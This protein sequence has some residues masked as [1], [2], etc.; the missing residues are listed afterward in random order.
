MY[1][2]VGEYRRFGSLIG[3]DGKLNACSPG[4]IT[5]EDSLPVRN[6]MLKTFSACYNLDVQSSCYV[7]FEIR[8][9][10]FSIFDRDAPQA[11]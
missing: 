9:N 11:T 7:I 4:S 6:I 2:V 3:V 8:S 1:R 10:S 5:L